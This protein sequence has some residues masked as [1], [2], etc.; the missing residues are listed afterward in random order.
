MSER[1]RAPQRRL[2]LNALGVLGIIAISLV[3]YFS[4]A[5]RVPFVHGDRFTVTF[6]NTSQLRKGSPVRIA[7]VDVGKVVGIDDGPGNTAAVK[8]E[9]KDSGL[10]IHQDATFRV[11]PRLFLEG[12]FYIEVR[13]GSPS[14][15]VLKDGGTIPL[16][17]TSVP[18]QFDQILS[19]L[20]HPTRDSLKRTVNN[21][22]EGLDDGAAKAFGDAAKP[23]IPALRNT[24]Q[25]AQ[26]TRGLQS[27]DLSDLIASLGRI[28]GTLAANDTQLG[29]LIGGLSTATGALASQ[30]AN[31]RA[32]VR[33]LDSL[34]QSSVPALREIDRVNPVVRRFAAALRPSLP[35][36]TT[37][38][39]HTVPAL[40]QARGLA[41]RQELPAALT[42]LTPTIDRLPTLSTRLQALFPLVTPVTDCVRDRAVPVL[43]TTI[44]DGPNSTNRPVWQDLAHAAVGLASSSSTFD[45]NGYSIRY[46]A[47]AGDQSIATGS[48]PG[49]GRLVGVGP[50][51][52][53]SSPRWLGNGV[54]LPFRPDQTC[55]DQALP[56][57]QART[58]FPAA[59]TTRAAAGRDGRGAA[60]TAPVRTVARAVGDRR[61]GAAPSALRD[62]L[63][64]VASSV[65]SAARTTRGG[66]R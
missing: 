52:E 6:S 2:S 43:N 16:G 42:A 38:L 49:L 46:I 58:P 40:D 63:R 34:T 3:V 19:S 41:G 25:L 65:R 30:Q 15:P 55:R 39:R 9:F 12:G 17:Q 27:H 54:K 53:G 64:S 7:G 66:A 36:L 23:F 22:S 20:D 31:L 62:A 11:R 48:L 33:G 50:Q 4:F 10:P 37:T 28:T 8:V 51:I 18:V 57:L 1:R 35:Q 56:D 21:L 45:G 47:A 32:T 59:A 44:N 14:A 61:A 29:Q 5:K 26:A 13:A 24:A 60:A